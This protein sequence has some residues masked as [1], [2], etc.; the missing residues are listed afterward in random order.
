MKNVATFYTNYFI[1]LKIALLSLHFVIF[2]E[3]RFDEVMK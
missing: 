1:N 2:L 3:E